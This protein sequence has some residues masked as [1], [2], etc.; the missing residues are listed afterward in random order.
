VE[1][2]AGTFDALDKQ[3]NVVGHVLS[4]H[5]KP[6]YTTTVDRIPVY[7]STGMVVGHMY[8]DIGFLSLAQS[9]D[10]AFDPEA[11]K[12]PVVVNEGSGGG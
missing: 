3:G 8:H 11:L 1:S 9:Q 6:E 7:D 12:R 5:L 4:E 10:A 2:S